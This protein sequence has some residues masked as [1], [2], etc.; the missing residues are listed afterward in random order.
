MNSPLTN[1]ISRTIKISAAAL[2]PIAAFISSPVSANELWETKQVD[3]EYK[4][5]NLN[6][7]QGQKKLVQ[8]VNAA[9]KIVCDIRSTRNINE[10]RNMK[11]CSAKATKSAYQQITDMIAGKNL[12][13]S[14]EIRLA[15]TSNI[16]IGNYI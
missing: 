10:R 16:V 6:S 15:S 2:L 5:L 13:I 7:S 9:V 14:P 3:V 4:D 12:E 8:R 1:S 11:A